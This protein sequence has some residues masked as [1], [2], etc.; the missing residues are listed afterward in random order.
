MYNII[1]LNDKSLSELQA[2]AQELGIK[3]ADTLKKEEL[4]Y[5][6]LDEQAIAG[7]TKKIAA[8]KLKEERKVE[9]QKRA[10]TASKNTNTPKADTPNNNS[11]PQETQSQAQPENKEENKTEETPATTQKRKPGRPRKVKQ[12]AA[13][14]APKSPQDTQAE[15]PAEPVAD[16]KPEE[17]AEA[18][19]QDPLPTHFQFCVKNHHVLQ[20][21]FGGR[22]FYEVGGRK[23]ELSAGQIFYL[24]KDAPVKY[25]ADSRDPYYYAWVSLDGTDCPRLLNRTGLTSAEPVRALDGAQGKLFELFGLL[26]EG[27]EENLKPLDSAADQYI[28]VALHYIHGNFSQDLTVQQLA[29]RLGLSRSYFCVLFRREVGMPPQQYLV[30][31]RVS[32]ACKLLE[33]GYRVTE[34]G[35]E[36]GFNS[37][38]HFSAQF[39]LVMGMSPREY[40]AG[41]KQRRLPESQEADRA[42]KNS[43]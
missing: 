11:A 20:Y 21:M 42:G 14:A 32:Q 25:Y 27:L 30:R 8:D 1:Q 38:S 41:L 43:P 19:S 40:C 28:N 13:E 22:G 23:Y 3:K 29:D 18:K 12:E 36:C 35:L 37:P 6:I 7:A 5:K 31:Y 16:N 26:C 39:S 24:P 2:I 17:K 15:K 4:V 33:A 34:A 9:K 10:R